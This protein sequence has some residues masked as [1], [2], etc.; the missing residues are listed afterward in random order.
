[1]LRCMWKVLWE[2]SQTKTVK[3]MREWQHTML[4]ILH[5]QSRAMPGNI[6]PHY[7]GS[8]RLVLFSLSCLLCLACLRILSRHVHTNCLRSQN[9]SLQVRSVKL[10]ADDHLKTFN[11][12]Q[13]PLNKIKIYFVTDIFLKYLLISFLI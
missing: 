7:P 13:Y 1:M 4:L 9:C 11:S 6:C 8:C 2:S 12:K 5:P 10:M 3:C